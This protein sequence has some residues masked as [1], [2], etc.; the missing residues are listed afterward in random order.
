MASSTTDH[1]LDPDF[2]RVLEEM[3]NRYMRRPLAVTQSLTLSAQH[4]TVLVDA[5]GGAKTITV[6]KAS[7]QIGRPYTVKKVDASANTVT[8]SRSGSDNIEGA[9]TYVLSAQH[10][11]VTIQS[12]AGTNWRVISKVAAG[13][14][15]GGEINTASNVNVGGV[16]VFKQKTGVNLE[17]RGVNAASTK[18]TVALDAVNNEVDVDASQQAILDA[19]GNTRGSFLER[20]LSSWGL[21][22]PGSANFIL[23]SNGAGADP[24]YA[25]LI[26][27]LDTVF[28]STRGAILERGASAWALVSPGTAN[29]V[30]T[31]NGA[32]A[33]PSYTGLSALIDAVF[34]STRGSILTRGASGWSLLTPGTAGLPV[35]SAGAGADPSYAPLND[36]P[37]AYSGHTGG[38]GLAIWYALGSNNNS[39]LTTGAVVANTLYAIPFVAPFRAGPPTLD[40]LAFNVTT[41]LAG[42][43]RAGI[44]N[45]TSVTNL[46][47]S[48]LVI[49]GGSIAT[50][51]T[52]VKAATISQALTPG[53]LYW[54][55]F[56]ADVAATL[57]THQA[58]TVGG[59]L[60]FDSTL[61][62]GGNRGISV[63]F[64]FAALPGTFPVSAALITTGTNIPAVFGRYSA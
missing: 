19:V 36:E 64:T 27:H 21:L 4:G 60:G 16:G 33:D 5:T 41:L 47:P 7:E 31:S 50:G 53:K 24:S 13:G 48:S 14:G 30:F 38:G 46:Y 23:I 59:I 56:V 25:S 29:T 20:G 39:S 8:L 3:R 32:G 12:D 9:T 35:V 22:T 57:R 45:S 52:G 63:A 15:G 6:P 26:T 2:K 43:G 51:T 37:N 61:P 54:A 34:G 55:V 44:Y 40:R 42:N 1:K 49:D 18:V 10:D 11:S 17:F 58:G 28:G 62:N